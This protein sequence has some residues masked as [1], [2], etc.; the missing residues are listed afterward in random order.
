MSSFF[1]ALI[2][3]SHLAHHLPICLFKLFF[4]GTMCLSQPV[5]A[6][7]IIYF[8]ET[9]TPSTMWTSTQTNHMTHNVLPLSNDIIIYLRL[10]GWS[11]TQ[12]KTCLHQIDQWSKHP[13]DVWLLNTTELGM[14][15]ISTSLLALWLLN[16]AFTQKFDDSFNNHITNLAKDKHSTKQS[17]LKSLKCHTQNPSHPKTKLPS[18]KHNKLM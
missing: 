12:I 7:W 13:R 6:S 3:L 9:I 1:K 16:K 11:F 2:G 8:T 17:T 5:I 4:F 14:T 10:L 15:I 18:P